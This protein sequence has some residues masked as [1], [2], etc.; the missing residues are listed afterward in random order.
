MLYVTDEYHIVHCVYM[1]RKLHRGLE[2]ES[3]ELEPGSSEGAWID[4]YTSN[5]MHTHHCTDVLLLFVR[6]MHVSQREGWTDDGVEYSGHNH[7][8][9]MGE[10]LELIRTTIITKFPSCPVRI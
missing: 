5:F 1:W 3:K 2:V 7:R 6:N 9:D 8:S 10:D 4:S